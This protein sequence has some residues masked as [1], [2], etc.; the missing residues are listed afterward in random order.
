MNIFRA[1]CVLAM[2]VPGAVPAQT[3]VLAVHDLSS[4]TYHL[5]HPLHRIEA[6]S[7]DVLFDAIV[8][9]ATR[10]VSRVSA[11]VDVMT[12]DSGNSNR[13]SHAMEVI[14]A[15]SFPDVRFSST[16]IL[17]TGD[18]AYVTGDLTFHGVTKPVVAAMLL[19]WR[20]G[21][22]RAEGGMD[23]SLQAFGIE[24]PSLLMIPVE[25]DLRF[26]IVAVFKAP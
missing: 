2:C 6:T 16:S 21:G 7:K 11:N 22:L 20:D 25:D 23:V 4:V 26:E 13:D 1:A 10:T 9:M 5:I 24:R 12:F 3:R 8:D 14:D 19:H 17:Q 18:S 15:L